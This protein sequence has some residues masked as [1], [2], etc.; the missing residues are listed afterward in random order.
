MHVIYINGTVRCIVTNVEFEHLGGKQHL[1]FLSVSLLFL[2]IYLFFLQSFSSF[3][4][5]A[6]AQINH[7]SKT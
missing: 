2:T 4:R 5:S 6:L 3:D 7:V 1:A